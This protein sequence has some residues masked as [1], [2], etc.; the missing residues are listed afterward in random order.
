[1]RL[2]GKV[3]IVTGGASGIGLSTARLFAK[4]GASVALCD[5]DIAGG[6]AA[7]RELRQ[8]GAKALFVHC[9][10]SQE[11]EIQAMMEQTAV[12][13]GPPTVLFNNAGIAGP[14]GWDAK[15]SE[16]DHLWE[17]N[18]K[19]VYWGIKHVLPHMRAAGKGSIINTASIGALGGG[20]GV[21][22]SYQASKAA[23][24]AFTKTAAVV[25]AREG[26]RVNA[27]APGV[28]E[29]PLSPKFYQG[30]ADPIAARGERVKSSP[31]GRMGQPEEVAWV[32]VFL[33]SEE[34]SYINGVVIPIDGG[35]VAK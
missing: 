7:V 26:I 5:M 4:E 23:V 20:M 6:E 11:A 10:V 22:P 13:L 34:A 33:A 2:S 8:A 27:V 18:V 19:G 3:A 28:I 9:D 12:E 32:V 17:V 24:V 14:V 15:A 35:M 29:T 1:M 31:M 21:S 16:L 25:L 30:I